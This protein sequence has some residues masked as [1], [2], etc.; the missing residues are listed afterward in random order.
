MVSMFS[1]VH[2]AVCF[3]VDTPS[4]FGVMWCLTSLFTEIDKQINA[5]KNN[6]ISRRGGCILSHGNIKFIY[7]FTRF[8]I[9]RAFVLKV[10]CLDIIKSIF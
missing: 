3:S 7:T 5:L 6:M 4:K 1:P 2:I 8:K 9:T 10:E